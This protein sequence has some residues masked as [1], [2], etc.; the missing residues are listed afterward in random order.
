M[1]EDALGKTWT[2][3]PTSNLTR[4]GYPAEY[5][6]H[7]EEVCLAIGY[8]INP[9]GHPSDLSLLKS[10]SSGEPKRDANR[11]WG[12]F[13]GVASAELSQWRF[14]PKQET[15]LPRAVYTVS[16]F[17]FASPSVL[18]SSKRCEIPNLAQRIIELKQD[19]RVHRR[20]TLTSVF[21]RLD[22]DRTLE[23]RYQM[24]RSTGMSERV[25]PPLPPPPPPRPEGTKEG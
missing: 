4:L 9:D 22:L 25:G 24:Y 5:R 12:A 10:W 23:A 14:V 2:L 7:Q 16:T 19:T 18:E 8:V 20:M 17:L 1:N 6:D 15:G 3:P 21:T 13:A 11:Y